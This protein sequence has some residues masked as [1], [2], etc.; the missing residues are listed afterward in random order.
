MKVIIRGIALILV[1]H[2]LFSC[3][4]SGNIL[5][6]LNHDI[7]FSSV[8]SCYISENGV[9]SDF[10]SDD[11]IIK[12]LTPTIVITFTHDMADDTKAVNKYITLKK[13]HG[14]IVAVDKKR[15]SSNCITITPIHDL[16]HDTK[17]VVSIEK[18]ARNYAGTELTKRFEKSFRVSHDTTP[19][20]VQSTSPLM[21]SHDYRVSESIDIFFTEEI[22][23]ETLEQSMKLY[24]AGD[25]K[26]I[27]GIIKTIGTKSFS[28]QPTVS[29]IPFATYQFH[30][31]TDLEDLNSNPL[32]KTYILKFTVFGEYI[33][34][35]PDITTPA[36]M[37]VFYPE[38]LAFDKRP[39]FY[40]LY[41]GDNHN[42]KICRYE[43]NGTYVTSWD[44][45]SECGGITIFY[46]S[47][48]SE[49]ITLF[50]T[51]KGTH[52][53]RIC[54]ANGNYYGWIGKGGNDIPG[55]HEENDPLESQSGN[56]N[57]EFNNPAGIAVGIEN[58]LFVVDSGN[59]RVQRLKQNG[60]YVG[61][62]GT[63]GE[64]NGNFN[65]PTGIAIDSD[66]NIYVV[67]TGNNRIQKFRYDGAHIRS[68][69]NDN[70]DI[71]GN[72]NNPTRIAVDTDDYVYITDKNNDRIL[73]FNR[74]G[75]FMTSWGDDK[76]DDH[77]LTGPQGITVH[78]S[79]TVFV[80]TN[81]E[82]IRT[83]KINDR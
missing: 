60:A 31:G 27:D 36:T 24:V 4:N 3:S 54:D 62:W 14:E 57:G 6:D 35:A 47:E 80:C 46:P 13:W 82:V 52:R 44:L 78:K 64:E 83:F 7:I 43:A 66:K 72:L 68:W 48:E 51:E 69:G 30:I 15:Q 65:N 32:F 29:L 34:Q 20:A 61:Q 19:P 41:V 42:N 63:L 17:Y 39:A 45:V 76:T 28:F 53:I 22:N 10:S 58:H 71:Y 74:D 55:L 16:S 2:C 25:D 59:N 33:F 77:H 11:L 38:V 1:F 26:P 23:T 73:K 40:D 67:D 56:G 12:D 9:T 81:N 21:N 37:P 70:D 5:D 75:T 18:K 49:D 79:G 8:Y 50:I